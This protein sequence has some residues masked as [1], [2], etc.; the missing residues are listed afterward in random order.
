MNQ[1]KSGDES[2]ADLSS[3]IAGSPTSITS[4]L[5]NISGLSSEQIRTN[6][7]NEIISSEQ[8]YVTHLK[9]VCEVNITRIQS[10]VTVYKSVEIRCF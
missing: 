9:D 1:E 6:I 4:Q 5:A 2:A 3:S 7:I 8:D 10:G